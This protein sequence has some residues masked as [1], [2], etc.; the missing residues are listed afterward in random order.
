MLG[1][2]FRKVELPPGITFQGH[3]LV[4]PGSLPLYLF[5]P[6]SHRN[7]LVCFLSHFIHFLH[8][9]L[10]GHISGLLKNQWGK[11][12]HLPSC[13]WSKHRALRRFMKWRLMLTIF[14]VRGSMLNIRNTVVI[15]TGVDDYFRK[16][17]CASPNLNLSPLFCCF[18][19]FPF[20]PKPQK[21]RKLA[22]DTCIP[23]ILT[24]L[25]YL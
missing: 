4:S 24:Y 20:S 21:K 3:Y 8:L 19:F 10:A 22:L 2:K 16:M 17:E 7:W 11:A 14:S 12:F 23:E 25:T 5:F 1:R 13:T 15:K 18:S 9:V 6:D